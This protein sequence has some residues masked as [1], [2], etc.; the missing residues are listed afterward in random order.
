ML[1]DNPCG[2]IRRVVTSAD[3]DL[4][5]DRRRYAGAVF[6]GGGAAVAGGVFLRRG[7][8]TNAA[9]APLLWPAVCE[10][11][12]SLGLYGAGLRVLPAAPR[13]PPPL[14]AALPALLSLLRRT[15]PACVSRKGLPL[16][17]DLTNASAERSGPGGGRMSK[18]DLEQCWSVL[19][20]MNT[21]NSRIE[22]PLNFVQKHLTYL[23]D[24]SLIFC[25]AKA[26]NRIGINDK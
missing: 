13:P 2:R 5:T 3:A 15:L 23:S 14:A 18:N 1:R 20:Q 12:R 11:V 21:L 7:S 24:H 25:N 10:P 26:A 9:G 4:N 19:L 17:V 6:L 8:A 16:T 22:P